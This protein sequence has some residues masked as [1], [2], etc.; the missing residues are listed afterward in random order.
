MLSSASK[1]NRYQEMSTDID[2]RSNGY[3]VRKESLMAK[4]DAA[5]VLIQ[6][7]L[8]AG[9]QADYVLMDT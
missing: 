8:N 3:K 5:I 2:H 1:S 4:T 7:A 6:R 9:I